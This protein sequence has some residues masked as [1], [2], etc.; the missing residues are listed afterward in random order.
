MSTNPQPGDFRLTIRPG[1]DAV[2]TVVRLR[3]LLKMLLRGYGFR[4]ISVEELPA[5]VAPAAQDER[6]DAEA[7]ECPARPPGFAQDASGAS[8]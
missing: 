3:R 2:P 1:R 4:C 7:T 8:G 6:G 5:S